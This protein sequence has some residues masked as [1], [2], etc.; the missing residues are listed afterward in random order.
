M[1]YR[2]GEF[3]ENQIAETK[4]W[5]RKKLFFLLCVVDPEMKD[6][7]EH[8]EPDAAFENV[9]RF[10]SGFNEILGYPKEIVLIS[11]MVAAALREYQRPEYD[12]AVCKKLL[13]GA[14]NEVLK[15]EEV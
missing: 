13:L 9:L 11:S 6:R 14:G 10:I 8:I 1:K 3:T 4:T 7:Y 12:F 15:I 2:Y 5:L